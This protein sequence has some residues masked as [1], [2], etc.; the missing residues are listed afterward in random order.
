MNCE[1]LYGPHRDCRGYGKVFSQGYVV[2][3]VPAV[4][5]RRRGVQRAKRV[6][7]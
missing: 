5:S 2:K 7:S 3:N 1:T 4:G 6:W